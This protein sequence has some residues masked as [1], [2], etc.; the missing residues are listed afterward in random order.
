MSGKA[1]FVAPKAGIAAEVVFGKSTSPEHR[2]APLLQRSD[3][4]TGS[5]YRLVGG[6]FESDVEPPLTS[7]SAAA[8]AA[9][10]SD[11][12]GSDPFAAADAAA[13]ARRRRRVNAAGPTSASSPAFLPSRS[14]FASGKGASSSSLSLSSFASALNSLA[15]TPTAAANNNSASVGC[16]NDPS[17]HAAGATRGETLATCSGNWLSHLDW[18]GKRA[19]TLAEEVPAAWEPLTTTTTTAGSSSKTPTLP[20]PSD[21][22]N[23]SDLRAL[24]AAFDAVDDG[25]ITADPAGVSVAQ[26]AKEILEVAQR[27]DAK[28]RKEG[29]ALAAAAAK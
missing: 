8:A 5:V 16:G 26:R 19:W 13:E 25:G 2:S 1:T 6:D 28:I 10:D 29:R 14:A 9:E 21:A 24:A 7:S 12:G 4:V 3:T 17:T 22:G 20:L 23:R 15:A 11:R 27:A 18:D